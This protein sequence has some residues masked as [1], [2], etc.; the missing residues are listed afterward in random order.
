MTNNKL[1]TPDEIKDKLV[2]NRSM[3]KSFAED[4]FNLYFAGIS[5]DG[6][7]IWKCAHACAIWCGADH[8]H[9]YSSDGLHARMF[10]VWSE[11]DW[12]VGGVMHKT[13]EGWTTNDDDFEDESMFD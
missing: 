8:V 6:E 4:W 2:A 7:V 1:T 11:D 10:W 12:S 9:D 5:P 13:S 3:S